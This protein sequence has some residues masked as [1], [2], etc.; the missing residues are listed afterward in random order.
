MKT[1]VPQKLQVRRLIL[2]MLIIT[3]GLLSYAQTVPELVFRNAT[4]ISGVDKQDG[5]VYRFSNIVTDVDALLTIDSRSSSAVQLSN[6]DLSNTGYD[7]AF[8]PQISYNGGNAPDGS[9]WWMQFAV[10]FV[11]SNTV[12]PIAVNSFKFTALDIDGDGSRLHEYVSFAK[13]NSYTLEANT[14]LTV[15]SLVETILNLLTPVKKFDGP[16][17]N[18]T[19]I[20]VTAT[21][22]MTTVTYLNASSFTF[23]AGGATSGGSSS[24]A[25]RMYSFWFKAIDYSA[26][27]DIT[28][29]L[30]LL[31]F[32]A[33]LDNAKADLKW[34]TSNEKNVSHFSVE[35]SLDGINFQEAA[36]VFAY[37][38]TSQDENYAYSDNLSTV[39][40]GMIYYRLKC[41]DA[42]GKFTY[43][44]V[45]MIRIGGEEALNNKI[46]TY[47]NPFVNELRITIPA[48]LQG[49]NIS[50]TLFNTN[51]QAV[52]RQVI[53]NASQT[54]T[55]N[56]SSLGRGMYIISISTGTQSIQNKI[57]K[58]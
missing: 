43:S 19:N 21:R 55:V 50:I 36:L 26:P 10:T 14:S 27:V 34:V 6:I 49:K 12:T 4:L 39:T 17:A 29:P 58:N 48:A 45:R 33:T 24:V 9:D 13:P 54:E 1:F 53:A 15:S 8:Q 42:D 20:D 38:N 11:K 2:L 30:N 25:D 47:P 28:L 37:G 31:S 18:Y 57:L 32:T 52:K 5:A 7:N 16:T 44:P 3:T 23:R 56:T 22:V 51:G 35:K 41:V 40:K 46:M